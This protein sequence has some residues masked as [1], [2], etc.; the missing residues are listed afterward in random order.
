[1]VNVLE[2]DHSNQTA[3]TTFYPC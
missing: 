1:V 2:A 3:A